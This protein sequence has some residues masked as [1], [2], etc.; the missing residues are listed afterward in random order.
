MSLQEQMQ[1]ALQKRAQQCGGVIP[2]FVQDAL[3]DVL[4]GSDRG[5]MTFDY[6]QREATPVKD[7]VDN[8]LFAY[9]GLGGEVGELLNIRKKMERPY[10]YTSQAVTELVEE[11]GDTLFY[12]RL[13]LE[14]EGRTLEEAAAVLLDKLRKQKAEIESD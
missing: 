2:A 1:E 6:F 5:V 4:G 13:A 12:L 3:E 14:K 10:G 7:Q 9:V 8:P 11:A